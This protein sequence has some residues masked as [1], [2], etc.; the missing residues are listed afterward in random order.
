M[1]DGAALSYGRYS[2]WLQ[3]AGDDLTPRPG[4]HGTVDAD[5]A[6][7]GAGFTGLWTAYYL[8]RLDPSLRIALVEKEIAGFGGSGRNGGWCSAGFALSP[9]VLC[10]RVGRDAAR[11]MF[12][13]LFEA[14]DEVG[15]AFERESIRADYTKGGSLRLALGPHQAP[16]LRDM[17]EGSRTLGLG[18]HYHHLDATEVAARVRVEG[19]VGG[20]YSPHAAVL[21]PGKAVRGLA[22]VVEAGGAT[23]YEQT[24]V[25]DF[26]PGR[27]VTRGGELRARTTVLAGES[28]LS[29]LPRMHR[30]VAPVYSLIALSEPLTDAQWEEI[31]WEG[32]ECVASCRLSVDYLQ[33]TADGRILFGGRGA[34]YRFGSRIRDGYDRHA[35]THEVLRTIARQW[36]PPLG[37]VHF[38]HAWGGPLGVTRDWMPSIGYDPDRG[39]AWS[40]GYAGQGVSTANVAGQTLAELLTG[41]P[42]PR[43][44]LPIVGH[45]PRRWEPEPLRWLG[46]RWVQSGYRRLD[47]RSERTASP[48]TGRSVAERLGRH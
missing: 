2:F 24:E 7:L 8:Q 15:T 27:L 6:I 31:G 30:T 45:D 13:A 43:T 42:S 11:A 37:N 46:I 1:S 48:P 4:L 5:V 21:H 19:A 18:D 16:A 20:V 29:R 34:P 32:R 23:L 9:T 22:R 17:L 3:T 39:L 12:C 14:V 10:E 40:Y 47:E 36:F 33:R 28:Y 26:A 41:T 44:Q 38:T 25:V 35:G